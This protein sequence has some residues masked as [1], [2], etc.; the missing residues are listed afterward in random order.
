MSQTP[1]ALT[2]SAGLVPFTHVGWGFG[3]REQFWAQAAQY[4][5]EGLGHNQ[6]IE[7]VAD[8]SREQLHAELANLPGLSE[9]IRVSGIGVTPIAQFYGVLPGTQVMD[10]GLAVATCVAAVD[11]ATEDGYSGLRVVVDATALA[12]A[13]RQRDALARFEFLVSQQMAVLPF[14][15][16]C[17]YDRGQLGDAG[18]EELICLHPQAGPQPPRLRFHPVPGGSFA[19]SG[20]IDAASDALYTA[21]LHRIWSLTDDDPVTID[22]S[23]LEFITHRQLCT[24]DDC[25][26]TDGRRVIVRTHQPIP[27]RLAGLLNLSNVDVAAL[28][29]ADAN[30]EPT[31]QP[32][33]RPHLT[34]STALNQHA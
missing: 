12:R 26:R 13:H 2:S 18:A 30:T 34:F 16:L 15:S 33:E 8:G 32:L 23:D 7:F 25:A 1:A 4:I 17:A 24:L 10:P 3:H 20:D 28:P 21:T 29:Q 27:A 11:K 5:L 9:R 6:R 31:P 19:L 14:S 22:A